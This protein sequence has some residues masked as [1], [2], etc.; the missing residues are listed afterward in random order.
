MEKNK[1]SVKPPNDG[2]LAIALVGLSE[3]II[4][5]QFLL[6]QDV[7][8]HGLGDGLRKFGIAGGGIE[9]SDATIVAAMQREFDEEVGIKYKK[10][11]FKKFGCYKKNRF[12]GYTNDN[13]LFIIKLNF[14]PNQKFSTNDTAEVSDIHVFKLRE[15][16]SMAKAGMVHEGSIRLIFLYL[17]GIKKGSLNDPVTWNGYTF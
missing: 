11:L 17:L 7:D 4:D 1:I 15:I 13:H 14:P 8:D 3:E 10:V 12:G 16:I 9:K 5:Q 2:V 6:I